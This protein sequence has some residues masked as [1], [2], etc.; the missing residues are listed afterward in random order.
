MPDLNL[1]SETLRFAMGIC[2][3]KEFTCK[4]TKEGRTRASAFSEVY[5]ALLHYLS[6]TEKAKD[7][8]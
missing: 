1:D 7:T 8:L 5:M 4:Q 3:Q 2:H 6:E